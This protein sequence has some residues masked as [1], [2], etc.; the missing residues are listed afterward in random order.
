[1]SCRN[2]HCFQSVHFLT[3][4]TAFITH[5]IHVRECFLQR[6]TLQHVLKGQ[7]PHLRHIYIHTC[8]TPHS[9]NLI[10][11]CT[12]IRSQQ[13]TR[14]TTNLWRHWWLLSELAVCWLQFLQP[15]HEWHTPE[16]VVHSTN[17]TPQPTRP[18]SNTCH[19]IVLYFQLAGQREW[20]MWTHFTVPNLVNGTKSQLLSSNPLWTAAWRQAPYRISPLEALPWL[21]IEVVMSI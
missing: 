7:T 3:L 14:T 10:A 18:H 9:S 21:S 17:C 15:P 2:K 8:D 20:R 11:P 12:W 19:C 5:P 6:A 16:T 13:T 4:F 1:M